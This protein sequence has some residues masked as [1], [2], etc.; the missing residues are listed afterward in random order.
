[1]HHSRN[2]ILI[3]LLV[4]G[5]LWV[6]R[7]CQISANARSAALIGPD[8]IVG[9]IP[10]TI[11]WGAVGNETAI[12]IATTSCN[13]GD[14]KL[15]WISNTNVHPVITQNLYRV[16]N[17]RI[18]MLGSAWLKHGFSVAAGNTCG[19]CTD[20]ASSYLA[21]NCSDPY[22][23]SL[24]GT[25]NSRLGPRWQVNATTGIF[26]YPNATL[27]ST[28]TLD[29]R[30]RFL[31]SEV[32]LTQN[33]G[34]R[35]FLESQYVHPQD[36]ASGNAANNASYR[37]AFPQTVTGGWDIKVNST[38]LI[39]RQQPAINAWK[40]VHSDVRLFNVDVPNDGRFVVGVRTTP[41]GSGYHTEIAV[42]NLNSDRSA[43]SVTAKFGSSAISNP[44]FRDLNYQFEPYSSTDWTPTVTQ[45]DLSWSTETHSQNQNANAL[46]WSTLY[47]FWCDSALPPRQIVLGMFK[48][49][50][51]S[52][53]VVDLATATA[54]T[55]F[56]LA[57]GTTTGG[58]FSNVAASD[59]QYW[60]L[61]PGPEA[62]RIVRRSVDFTLVGTSPTSA[63]TDFAFRLES[64]LA[65]GPAGDVIQRVEF[66]NFITGG[67]ELV[68]E[69]PVTTSDRSLDITPTGNWSRFIQTGTREVR[70][71]VKW[72]SPN[73]FAAS[74]AYFWSIL[75]DQAAWIT[76]N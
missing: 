45:N 6:I 14:T 5:C 39:V 63:P 35:Y 73:G 28:G 24:N 22:G 59:N 18:E 34:A 11:R 62:V 65:N 70:A 16:K 30:L 57:Q 53:M 42:E 29:G 41:S 8:V 58:Q 69:R 4:V 21:V 17:G 2:I 71:R 72:S 26:T 66:F 50:T 32:D 54:P 19:T 49:G 46:R 67:F 40:A 36:A 7:E 33:S 51:V 64:A 20:F 9:D 55:S 43:R 23:A 44:G 52:E 10:S 37:E 74:Q 27:P 68:D 76:S 60:R 1:M 25:Q 48:P 12:S 15:D 38:A 75:V 13:I 31:T 61:D 56:A 3:P 47:S